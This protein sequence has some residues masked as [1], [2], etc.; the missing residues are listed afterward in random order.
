MRS[1]SRLPS[2]LSSEEHESN[3]TTK[4]VNG[5]ERR[6]RKRYI[7]DSEE[8]NLT[9]KSSRKI[10]RPAGGR[11]YIESSIVDP[12]IFLSEDSPEEKK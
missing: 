11:P 12:V 7:T 8:I 2:Q 1:R 3:I 10:C 6:Y 9:R 5:V 4:I